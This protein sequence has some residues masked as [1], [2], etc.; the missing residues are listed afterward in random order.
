[1]HVSLWI[2]AGTILPSVSA[3]DSSTKD[4]FTTAAVRLGPLFALAFL[5]FG[6]AAGIENDLD[7]EHSIG[8]QHGVGKVAIAM[9][10]VT[11]DRRS[12]ETRA[13]AKTRMLQNDAALWYT[14]IG[15]R[16]QQKSR[17]GCNLV[18]DFVQKQ[19]R[20]GTHEVREAARVG[21]TNNAKFTY[22]ATVTTSLTFGTSIQDVDDRDIKVN[23]AK[24]FLLRID[25]VSSWVTI[26]YEGVVLPSSL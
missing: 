17:V 12:R 5:L 4:A 21:S 10:T 19:A 16:L 15:T 6:R 13:I 2:I 7:T 24:S 18:V 9:G 1:M 25:Q 22:I 11:R 26:G 20:K 8:I 3:A 14:D 23:A